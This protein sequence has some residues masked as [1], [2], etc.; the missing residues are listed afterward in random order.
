MALLD[1]LL[2]DIP[3]IF[4]EYYR[5][6]SFNEIPLGYQAHAC[7]TMKTY[8]SKRLDLSKSEAEC[9]IDISVLQKNTIAAS[10]PRYQ[11]K[12]YNPD[13]KWAILIS[14]SLRVVIC[15]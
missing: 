8:A 1:L 7:V 2:W 11:Q 3:G 12:K 10:R 5:E 14:K 9:R 6:I 4:G 15:H 13:F